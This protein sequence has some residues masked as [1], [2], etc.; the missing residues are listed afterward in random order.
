MNGK[1]LQDMMKQAERMQQKLQEEMSQLRVEGSSGGGIVSVV[2]DGGKQ[3]LS[4]E[5]KPEAVD[6]EDVEMLQDLILAAVSEAARKVDEAMNAQLG[7][8]TG[9]LLPGL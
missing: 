6:P 7:G 1:K 2:M 8:L 4:I 3:L 5:I 9:G